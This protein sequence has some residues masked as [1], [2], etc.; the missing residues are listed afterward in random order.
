VN[1]IDLERNVRACVQDALR[2]GVPPVLVIGLLHVL[3]DDVYGQL[4]A[5]AADAQR[6]QIV[7]A[8]MVP[9]VNGHG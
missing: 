6:K 1:P 7:R 5:A 8:S 2:D 3:A 4:K 9:P